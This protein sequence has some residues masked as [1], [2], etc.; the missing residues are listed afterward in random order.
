[1]VKVPKSAAPSALV[2]R[3]GD[4]EGGDSLVLS[5]Y[6]RLEPEDRTRA[7]Y[8]I[9]LKDAARAVR[10]RLDSLPLERAARQ[11]VERDLSRILHYVEHSSDLPPARGLAIFASTPLEL[12][13]VVPLPHAYRTRIEIDR[14]PQLEELIATEQEF[15]RLLM[16][17]ADRVHARLFEITPFQAQELS[18][19]RSTGMRGGK[20][21]SDRQGSPGWG[22]AD[23]HNRIREEA[24]RHYDRIGQ[25]L[26]ARDRGGVARDVILAGPGTV[27]T[28]LLRFLPPAL[29]ERVIGMASLNPTEVTP[30]AVYRA[31]LHVT[32]TQRRA[33]ERDLVTAVERG[34]TAGWAVNGI[35]PTLRALANGQ[36]RVLLVGVDMHEPGYRCAASR[37]LAVSKTACL[38]EGE[39][40]P[41][42]D[43]VSDAIQQALQQH[44]SVSVIRDREAVGAIDGMAALLRFR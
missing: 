12:F 37:R 1:M 10:E 44:V 38:G 30:A 7:K 17:V 25:E 3:L 18:C 31:A 20:Y 34:C 28:T 27:P 26:L 29:T 33:G 16:V 35:G 13:A 15:G 43:V 40:V 19:C 23:Y 9:E 36:V 5:C 4:I 2:D 11:I 6:V 22:E 24:Q 39:P 14:V 42:P 8:L 21:H 32:E 41:V